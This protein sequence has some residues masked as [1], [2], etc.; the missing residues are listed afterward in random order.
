MADSRAAHQRS[1]VVHSLLVR[2]LEVAFT[3]PDDLDAAI[4]VA[5][6]TKLI[7]ITSRR[8]FSDQLFDVV[9][10]YV[11][12]PTLKPIRAL[13]HG[14]SPGD[15][16][17][18][19]LEFILKEPL[20]AP[21]KSAE[22]GSEVLPLI[23]CHYA[24]VPLATRASVVAALRESAEQGGRGTV[25]AE[26]VEGLLC[27]FR[28]ASSL[29]SCAL[30][31]QAIL[32]TQLGSHG[33]PAEVGIGLY[34][35]IADEAPSR[36]D[37]Y[38]AEVVQQISAIAGAGQ[39]L[40][41]S[42]VR[43]AVQ[44]ADFNVPQGQIAWEFHRD[45]ALR[46]GGVRDLHEVADISI[47]QPSEPPAPPQTLALPAS[48]FLESRGYSGLRRLT[49]GG[50]TI[51]YQATAKDGTT[52]AIKV[53][54]EGLGLDQNLNKEFLDRATAVKG[55]THDG[56]V[57]ILEVVP[58]ALP[59]FVMEW[60]DGVHFDVAFDGLDGAARLQLA[61]RLCEALEVAHKQPKPVLHGDL[62]PSNIL[63]RA[64][65]P[66]LLD[67]G[68]LD[69]AL[70]ASSPHATRR[71]RG[72]PLYVAPELSNG[73]SVTAAS[74]IYSL[75]VVL[76]EA[77]VGRPPFIGSD[78]QI[79]T[80]HSEVDPPW[81]TGLN[82]DI[83]GNLERVLLKSLEKLPSNAETGPAPDRRYVSVSE[84]L[85]DLRTIIR[86]GRVHTRPSVYNNMMQTRAR[87]AVAQVD[88]WLSQKHIT[89]AEYGRLRR[90]FTP[91]LGTGTA[92]VGESR[93]T[94]PIIVLMYFLGALV[95]SGVTAL[96]ARHDTVLG[97][98]MWFRIAAGIALPLGMALIWQLCRAL[99]R[100]RASFVLGLLTLASLPI[101]VTN[102]LNEI[103]E[104]T[105]KLPA[106]SLV[107]DQV[108]F[109]D[110]TQRSTQV[111]QLVGGAVLN[112][113]SDASVKAYDGKC[114][115]SRFEPNDIVDDESG[116]R[117][118]ATGEDA[119][120]CI[121]RYL[122]GETVVSVARWVRIDERYIDLGTSDSGID[123]VCDDIRFSDS[124]SGAPSFGQ[125]AFDCREL[126]LDRRITYIPPTLTSVDGVSL[127]LGYS[128]PWMNDNL[129]KDP[130]LLVAGVEP[131]TEAEG[132]DAADCLNALAGGLAQLAPSIQGV[133]GEFLYR[134]GDNASVRAYD[135][136]CDDPRF[137]GPGAA[138]L[139]IADDLGHDASDC[140]LAA[141]AGDLVYVAGRTIVRN[142]IY[143]R[144]E[145]STDLGKNIAA[146]AD[147]GVCQDPRFAIGPFSTRD[148]GAERA[149]LND[150]L[151]LL[152]TGYVSDD[153]NIPSVAPRPPPS[154]FNPLNANYLNWQIFIGVFLAWAWA[155][156]ISRKSRTLTVSVVSAVL[157]MGLC[158][159]ALDFIGL[160]FL[161]RESNQR[162]LGSAL[163]PMAA[164]ILF[165][166]RVAPGTWTPRIRSA[167]TEG[168]LAFNRL[169]VPFINVALIFLV[170]G[171]TLLAKSLPEHIEYFSEHANP[172]LGTGWLL[173]LSG[174]GYFL[175]ALWIRRELFVEAASSYW[176]L[177][178]LGTLFMAGG[179]LIADVATL[180][181][182]G[183]PHWPAVRLFGVGSPFTLGIPLAFGVCF[184]ALWQSA[185][186]NSKALMAF[187]LALTTATVWYV[188]MSRF[189]NIA[190]WASVLIA[191]GTIGLASALSTIFILRSRQDIDD[192]AQRLIEAA[193]MGSARTRRLT[194]P[195][196]GIGAADR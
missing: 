5:W 98:D 130:R 52:V 95:V 81:P 23:Y 43:D 40:A 103:N 38:S 27:T 39:I 132:M 167:T 166:A 107:A 123:G 21:L 50:G 83:S 147:D 148:P 15:W 180:I 133:V 191:A 61:E 112:V 113:G 78:D 70:G 176:A 188:E 170:V 71:I 179:L 183:T 141:E 137:G 142:R 54:F 72:T 118:V 69:W 193:A 109:E 139:S 116:Q 88:R 105:L 194:P 110:P 44:G 152:K 37:A 77:F 85:A 106:W 7:S 73:E 115:D 146:F 119:S 34:L 13:L 2:L 128:H 153:R 192:V 18:P 143:S 184:F 22:S 161:L 186:L 108:L 75:G 90:A 92:A 159:I 138:P 59:F 10:A 93:L 63:V 47:R 91:L 160:R 102:T 64:G 127:I 162:F 155:E 151:Y 149:D 124:R 16:R 31:I 120:D 84:M 169:A 195:E 4:R 25:V 33:R 55:L 140:L 94:H 175:L 56:I 189:E 173:F 174:A 165:Y 76:Y 87:T 122:S 53:L 41:S 117:F 190:L 9:Q 57:R 125:D 145:V 68:Q 82:P 48:K 28:S 114:Q 99:G 24:K 80:A 3:G 67:F 20:S 129:C 49:S 100:Y 126:F 60:I 96:L 182:G 66:I 172:L 35:G 51:L 157:V 187:S 42:S 32:H 163:V 89:D 14:R 154:P 136:Q 79:I 178:Y 62:K 17:I 19:M 104:Q 121:A 58:A 177:I 97:T 12:D 181:W 185:R 135:E 150:C 11:S 196:L 134:L 74:D 46:T 111:I 86:G 156:F 36:P 30:S 6:N 168:P 1:V 45:Y 131:S 144:D 65:R 8:L 164:L 29:V 26:E 158:V 171:L 101:A